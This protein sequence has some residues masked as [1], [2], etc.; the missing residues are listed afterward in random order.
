MINPQQLNRPSWNQLTGKEQHLLFTQILRYFVNPLLPTTDIAPVRFTVQGQSFAS[1]TAIIA[2]QR[3]IFVPGQSQVQLGYQVTGKEVLTPRLWDDSE[4]VLEHPDLPTIPLTTNAQR[5]RYLTDFTTTPRVVHIPPLLVSQQPL[6]V[7]QRSI[8]LYTPATGD[9]SGDMTTFKMVRQAAGDDLKRAP[10]SIVTP[11]FSVFFV[12]TA[13]LDQYQVRID[14]QLTPMAL[15]RQLARQGFSVL[16]P[17]EYEY[18]VGAGAATLFPWGNAGLAQLP[19]A[20]P[21]RFGIRFSARQY[22]AEMTTDPLVWRGGWPVSGDQKM[23]AV[24]L[25]FSAFYN[26]GRLPGLGDLPVPQQVYHQVVRV[27]FE[28]ER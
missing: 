2:G 5:E 6:P 1:Q 23:A 26:S 13:V 8:G 24:Q 7:S 3:Y 20:L 28:D 15:T 17:D 12:P 19:T 9:F 21:N 4:V 10:R 16:A 25:P 14:Q 11:D 22:T 18:V 27:T